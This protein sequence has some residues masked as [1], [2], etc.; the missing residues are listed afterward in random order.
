MSPAKASIMA[1]LQQEICL[2]Q[3]NCKIP[4]AVEG[5]L[6]PAIARA[7]PNACFPQAAVHEFWHTGGATAS[8]THGFVTGLLAPMMKEGGTCIWIG[9]ALTIFPPALHRFGVEAQKIIFIT[10]EKQRDILWVMEEA[11]KCEG[12]AAVVGELQELSFTASRRLQLAVE[13]S[14]VTG[15]VLRNAPRSTNTTACVSR[16]RISSLPGKT[17]DL[18]GVGFPRWQVELLKVRNGTPGQWVITYAAGA[19]QVD[20]SKVPVNLVATFQKKTG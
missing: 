8:A 9:G 4:N 11:L 19:L 14:R 7:F 3:G 6:P 5:I 17:G 1:Q 18:P 10:L 2:L 20:V 15:L 13:K 16:W 12:L